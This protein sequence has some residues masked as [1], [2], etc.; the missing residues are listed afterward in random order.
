[1]D[2]EE[3]IKIDSLLEKVNYDYSV[4]LYEVLL[5]VELFKE[6]K[7]FGEK[8]QGS[9]HYFFQVEVKIY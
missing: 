5:N 7:I 8:H 3:A 9:I 2:F 4:H 6:T 1:M